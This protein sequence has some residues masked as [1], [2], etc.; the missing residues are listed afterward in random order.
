MEEKKEKKV[1]KHKKPKKGKGKKGSKQS[2]KDRKKSVKLKF[3]KHVLIWLLSHSG[4]FAF[5][6]RVDAVLLSE[7]QNTLKT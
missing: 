2:K 7:S 3:T 1:K 6:Y 5:L 4:N